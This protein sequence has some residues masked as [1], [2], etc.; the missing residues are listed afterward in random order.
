MTDTNQTIMIPSLREIE[1]MNSGIRAGSLYANARHEVWSAIRERY[2][3]RESISAV[4]LCTE[5]VGGEE[6]EIVEESE[7]SAAL[8]DAVEWAEILDQSIPARH[9]AQLEIAHFRGMALD[10]L[11]D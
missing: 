5:I 7:I 2:E 8:L 4:G 6:V 9:G 10:A 3:R 1:E 11:A